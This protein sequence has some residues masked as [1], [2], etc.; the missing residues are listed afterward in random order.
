MHQSSYTIVSAYC[1][2]GDDEGNDEKFWNDLQLLVPHDSSNVIIGGD[3][4]AHMTL[5]LAR[6]VGHVIQTDDENLYPTQSD[7]HA[8]DLS[9]FAL[10]NSLFIQN[11]STRVSFFHRITCKSIMA[12]NGG[13]IIDYCLVPPSL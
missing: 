8:V 5:T 6:T 7:T 10:R 1:P 11:F 12:A 9:N 3:F 2:F 4:N 13:T